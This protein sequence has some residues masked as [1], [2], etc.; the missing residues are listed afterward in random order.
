METLYFL[1]LLVGVLCFLG[2][3]LG[4]GVTAGADTGRGARAGLGALALLPLGLF[5][6][7]LPAVIE[8]GRQAF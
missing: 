5:F 3:A 2:A 8:T 7:F 4:R 6:V 1:L